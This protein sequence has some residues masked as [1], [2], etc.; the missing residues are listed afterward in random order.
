MVAEVHAV[1]LQAWILRRVAHMLNVAH[2]RR[3]ILLSGGSLT[4]VVL[5][6][7][8]GVLTE[9]PGCSML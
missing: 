9:Y 7:I 5:R 2:R 1:L 3:N 6:R 8:F 4:G